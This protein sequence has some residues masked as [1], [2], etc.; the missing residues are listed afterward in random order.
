MGHAFR[1]TAIVRA[2]SRLEEKVVAGIFSGVD[3]DSG[4][5]ANQMLPLTV[6]TGRFSG[7][8]GEVSD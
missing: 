2:G 7:K 3:Q 5:Y 4:V 8:S 6:T 1:Q